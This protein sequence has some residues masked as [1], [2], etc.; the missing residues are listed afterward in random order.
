MTEFAQRV[1]RFLTLI[2]FYFRRRATP[3]P[4]VP[5]VPA[6]APEPERARTRRER[7]RRARRPNAEM[8][9]LKRNILDQ[10]DDNTK[11]FGRMKAFFPTEYG[12]YSQVGAAIIPREYSSQ[13]LETLV[14]DIDAFVGE[15]LV[16]PWFNQARPAFGA[17]VSGNP[18]DVVPQRGRPLSPR[19]THFLKI[20]EPKE[21][22]RFGRGRAHDIIQPIGPNSDLYIFT[23]YYDEQ[24]WARLFPA[25]SR[26]DRD[27]TRFYKKAFAVE[28]PVEITEEGALRP[29]KIM[30]DERLK[31][32]Q[33][34]RSRQPM[35]YSDA[36][37][38][39]RT[40]DYPYGKGFSRSFKTRI[41]GEQ[42]IL[43][44]AS[45]ALSAYEE[46]SS[47]MIQV[48]TMK[49][50][51]CTL[52]NVDIEETPDFFLDREDV[53]ID[54]I[55]K[56]IFHIV[57]PHERL[58]GDN[59][60]TNVHMHFR[61]LRKFVWNGYEIEISVP[62]RDHVPI[63]EFDVPTVDQT[64]IGKTTEMTTVAAWLVANQRAGW[65]AMVGKPGKMVPLK[66]IPP[67]PL[68]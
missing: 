35:R 66:D 29:L 61:G 21:R 55:K 49:G 23:L 1:V 41:T 64:Y 63:D 30:R 39:V 65:G 33:T 51:I 48:R 59:R 10:L 42:L 54:G 32:G 11:I 47:S 53:I 20:K 26:D 24:D 17:L 9:R 46:A 50:D 28:L 27:L 16:S 15:P 44:E 62:G 4:I 31:I 25:K 43:H 45:A 52:I 56:R 38:S 12:L 3:A 6:P 67:E 14:F 36:C 34:P 5:V 60:S 22:R 68:P 40:W 58:L 18:Y 37:R 19:L 8:M 13:C 7:T 57:R 2:I